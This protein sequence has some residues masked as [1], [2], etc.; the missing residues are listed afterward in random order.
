MLV[1]LFHATISTITMCKMTDGISDTYEV[2]L[3]IFAGA[4]GCHVASTARLH[5]TINT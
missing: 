2:R 3:A 4:S 5:E 1:L